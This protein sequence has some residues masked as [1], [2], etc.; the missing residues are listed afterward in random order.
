M[1]IT[2]IEAIP[3]EAPIDRVYHRARQTARID[4]RRCILVRITT[5]DGL[6]GFGEGMTPITPL[7]AKQ[8]ID[9]I[10]AP[11]LINKDPLDHVPL[12]ETLYSINSSRGYTRG[13]QMIAISAVDIA[14]WDLKGRILDQ[15]VYKLLGGACHRELEVYAT[16]IMTDSDSSEALEMTEGYLEEGI[17][18]LKFRIGVDEKRD[19]EV[20]QALRKKFGDT[21][22]IM[23]DANGGYDPVAAIRM[24]RRLED[25]GVFFFEEPVMAE[26]LN[27]LAQV[28]NALSIYVA[29]GESEY[30]KYGFL[31]MF[32]KRALSICQP[33]VSRAGGITECFRIAT[34]AQAFNIKYAPHCFGGIVNL[35]ASAHLATA[36]P[37][38]VIFELDR[39]PNP[40]REEL[41]M[42]NLPL[43]EGYLKVT[44]SPG[45]GV[46]LDEDR[47]KFY[48]LKK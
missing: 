35:A 22:R 13:Y 1:K 15:P 16:G 28:K 45:L 37:N 29:A 19:V 12:W 4:A 17:K 44:D 6:V 10:L 40:L 47:I 32:E 27:G 8:I 38:F 20:L 43:E 36:I 23:V 34:M 9:E 31:D 7:P 5:D 39:F 25:H 24:G 14:L 46:N 42:E 18:G 11:F 41:T 3:L 2:S 33:D 21:I 30:T 48:T 26:D